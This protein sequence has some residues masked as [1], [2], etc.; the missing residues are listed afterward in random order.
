MPS[1]SIALSQLNKLVG[2]WETS[3][4]MLSGP[5]SG[6]TFSGSDTYQWLPGNTFMQHRWDVL[7]PDG[8]HRGI[9]IFGFHPE[10]QAIFAHAYDSDGS[11]SSSR[12]MFRGSQFLIET[13][14]LRFEGAL[15]GSGRS[16]TGTWSTV[17]NGELVMEV[18]FTSSASV[19]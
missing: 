5:D 1:K 12:V 16:M 13:D 6:K 19:V 3:G 2:S 8:P 11:F 9:E 10:D 17:D 14:A 4:T 18:T 7:M 15:D